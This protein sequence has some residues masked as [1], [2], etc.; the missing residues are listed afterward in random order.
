M[1]NR[2]KGKREIENINAKNKNKHLIKERGLKIKE[3]KFK[4]KLEEEQRKV[5]RVGSNEI[6]E[7]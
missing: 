1:K 6:T 7:S 5:R 3:Q 4:G 2:R